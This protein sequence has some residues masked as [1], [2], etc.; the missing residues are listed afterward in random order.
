MQQQQTTK[1]NVKKA[2]H[3]K[4]HDHHHGRPLP[5]TRFRHVTCS[6]RIKHKIYR[7]FAEHLQWQKVASGSA[8]ENSISRTARQV[9]RFLPGGEERNPH[10]RPPV[11]ASSQAGCWVRTYPQWDHNSSVNFFRTFRTPSVPISCLPIAPGRVGEGSPSHLLVRFNHC[12][13][14]GHLSGAPGG[15]VA[16]IQDNE[17]SV[18]TR[19][20]SILL[21]NNNKQ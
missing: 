14:L 3:Q 5:A 17:L 1:R 15:W 4:K 18:E 10:K 11:T 8:C 16:S 2:M 19:P 21:H 12:N 13:T 9:D 20:G 6:T 7:S